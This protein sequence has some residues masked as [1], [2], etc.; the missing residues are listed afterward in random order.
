MI[1]LDTSV[2]LQKLL[3]IY[4]YIMSDKIIDLLIQTGIVGSISGIIGVIIGVILQYCLS[5]KQRVFETKLEI[6][7][8]VYKQLYYFVLMNQEEI[9]LLPDSQSGI[10]TM[11]VAKSSGLDLKSDLGDLLYYVDGDL[12]KEIGEL[13]YKIY[14]EF[15]VIG[16]HDIDAIVDIMNRLKNFS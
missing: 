3:I 15:A 12:E 13:I 10:D 8:R 6:F 5:K 11:E 1:V 2:L 14:Q 9:E 7:R 4:Q 16:K